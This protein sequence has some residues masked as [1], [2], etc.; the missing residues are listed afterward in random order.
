MRYAV[1][2]DEALCAGL[3][4]FTT[5]LAFHRLALLSPRLADSQNPVVSELY[6]LYSADRASGWSMLNPFTCQKGRS[7]SSSHLM[8]IN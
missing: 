2:N 3:K 7:N 4:P 5:A 1:Y 8:Y 6:L